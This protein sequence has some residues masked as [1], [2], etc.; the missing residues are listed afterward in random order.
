MDNRKNEMY[1]V[2]KYTDSELYNIL[3]L[4]NPSDRELEAKIFFLIHKYENMQ[5]K[6]GNELANFFK[7]IYNHFFETSDDEYEE[8]LIEGMDNQEEDEQNRNIAN[9][10]KG[11]TVINR[12]NDDQSNRNAMNILPVQSTDN[13]SQYKKDTISFTKPVEYAQDK[14]NPLLQQ[15]IKRIISKCL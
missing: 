7:Q 12:T 6:S 14:L 4:I 8:Y 3:D 10:D 15:T 5:N 2:N 13:N 1:N 9:T 11:N